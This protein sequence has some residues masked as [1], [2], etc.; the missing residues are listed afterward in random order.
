M[1]SQTEA[2]SEAR[3]ALEQLGI[4]NALP[5]LHAAGIGITRSVLGGSHSV[6]IYPPIESLTPVDPVAVMNAVDC[7][8]DTSL[9][10]HIAFCETRCSF[11]HYAVQQLKVKDTEKHPEDVQLSR[12]LAALKRELLFWGSKLAKSATR[13]SSIYIGGGT[14]LLLKRETLRDI[15]DTVKG[16]YEILPSAEVCV[17]ASPLTITAADGPEKLQFLKE[18]GVTRLSFG[19]QSFDD[20]VLKYAARGYKRDLPIRAAQ[21][22]STI[23]DNWN[24]DLIQGLYKGSPFESWENLQVIS[25]LRPPHLTWYHGRFADRPQGDWYRSDRKRPDFEDERATLLGRML[26]WK[27]MANL[28]YHQTDGNRFAREGQFS[29][30]FKRI[31]TSPSRNLLGI[32]AASYSHLGT[33]ATSESGHGYVFRNEANISSYVDRV[34]SGNIPI[35]TGRVIDEKELLAMSYATGLRIGRVEDQH[36]R[37][38]RTAMPE[39]SA[40]YE[41]LERAFFDLQVLEPYIDENRSPGIRLS[42]LGRLFEDESLALFFSPAVKRALEEKA[43][44]HASVSA[45]EAPAVI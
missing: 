1:R 33:D 37:S 24:I 23:Y 34:L 13:L 10:V 41:K 36:L 25:Q 40:H 29:D 20:V 44:G 19:V 39:L 22:V 31:R 3:G 4:P 7:G 43:K 15:V 14:P 6:A 35:A 16:A 30:P 21:I 8:R 5:Q 38:I 27:E 11:C 32:G 9:Y 45:P 2:F 18:H 28:G 12:Y 17:E 42:I 26:I